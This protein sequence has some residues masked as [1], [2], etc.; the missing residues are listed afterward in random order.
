MFFISI[1]AELKNEQSF[2]IFHQN[3]QSKIVGGLRIAEDYTKKQAVQVGG[4]ELKNEQ[5]FKI[6]HQNFQSKIVTILFCEFEF[7]QTR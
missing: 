2:I 3:F 6:F 5:S 1:R 7:F 4:L